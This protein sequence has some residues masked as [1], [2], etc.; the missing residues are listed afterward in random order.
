MINK[1]IALNQ[2]KVQ[3]YLGLV[4]DRD[5]IAFYG[6]PAW[7]ATVDESHVQSPYTVEWTGQRQF[8]ITANRDTKER[9]AVWFPSTSIGHTGAKGCDAKDAVY[10][11]DFILFPTMDMKKG[12]KKV[13]NIR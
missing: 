8:T 11:N 5:V 7:S 6:D 13:V 4:H 2:E 3:D 10:T 9:C 1:G 12:E